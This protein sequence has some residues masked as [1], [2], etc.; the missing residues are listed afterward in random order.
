MRSRSCFVLVS[1]F[2]F[3][4]LSIAQRSVT[5]ADLEGYKDQRI[6]A[7]QDLRENY[8]RLG[9]PS[10]AELKR[11]EEERNRHIDSL[12]SRLRQQDLDETR[13]NREYE[14]AFARSQPQVIIQQP[15]QPENPYT[16]GEIPYGFPGYTYGVPNYGYDIFGIPRGYGRYPSSRGWGGYPPYLT[17]PQGYSSGGVF[18]PLGR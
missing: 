6:R 11:R 12:T 4:G 14:S 16:T 5:N 8:S 7:Q 1:I 10:P 17:T 2:V 15:E 9:F 18:W 13:I 3:A